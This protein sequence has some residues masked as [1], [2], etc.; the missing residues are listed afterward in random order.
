MDLN[1]KVVD[2][3]IFLIICIVVHTNSQSS[4]CCLSVDVGTRQIIDKEG[5]N[6]C[7][8]KLHINRMYIPLMMIVNS[9]IFI[10]DYVCTGRA[11]LFHGVNVVSQ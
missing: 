9:I 4:E 10:V 7:E 1:R 8:Y 2:F 11:R 6:L 5:K 3:I